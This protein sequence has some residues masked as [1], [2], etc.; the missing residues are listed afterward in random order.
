MLRSDAYDNLCGILALQLLDNWK[1]LYRLRPR[2]E[3]NKEMFRH[4]TLLPSTG[5]RCRVSKMRQPCAQK[6]ENQYAGEQ[7]IGMNVSPPHS[8]RFLVYSVQPLKPRRLN[9]GRRSADVVGKNIKRATHAHY[10]GHAEAVTIGSEKSFFAR[11]R[12][13]DEEAVSSAA[14]YLLNDLRLFLRS[15]IAI[16][17]S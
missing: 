1:E 6:G 2:S 15:E 4:L 16:P 5:L 13:A 3:Q 12:H 7:C 11:R 17:R 8:A 10:E 14:D 9:R